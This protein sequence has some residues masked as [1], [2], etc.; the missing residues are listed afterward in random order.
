MVLSLD[1]S[2]VVA[3]GGVYKEQGRIQHMLL[4]PAYK[5]FLIHVLFQGTILTTHT[6]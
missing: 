5:E 6:I 1:H 4:T 2:S 3:T